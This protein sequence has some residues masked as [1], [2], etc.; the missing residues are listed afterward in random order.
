MNSKLIITLFSLL[1]VAGVVIG[2]VATNRGDYKDGLSHQKKAVSQ[3]CGRTEYKDVCITT[4]DDAKTQDPKELLKAT[5]LKSQDSVQKLLDL[6]D[7]LIVDA[8]TDNRF[9][10]R[11]RRTDFVK[12]NTSDSTKMTSNALFIVH[13]WSK[14]LVCIDS[15]LKPTNNRRLLKVDNDKYPSWFSASDR[16]LLESMAMDNDTA[17]A[18]VAKDGSRDY[19]SIQE[20]IDAYPKDLQ[21]RYVT[22]V[23]GSKSKSLGLKTWKTAI[24]TAIGTGFI[25]K[26]MGFMNTAG[27][28]GRHA[29]ALRV[30]SDYSAILN[31]RIDG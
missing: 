23:T 7:R 15:N 28:D 22:I 31:C 6:S 5:I 17:H 26:S 21:G 27:S 1:L 3:F 9:E 20:A 30:A 29:V 4:L 12:D 10:N 2:F 14:I 25:A 13:E 11:L 24:F 16:K 19:S 18:V 8:S